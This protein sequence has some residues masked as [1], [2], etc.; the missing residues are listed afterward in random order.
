MHRASHNYPYKVASP[1]GI[2]VRAPYRDGE[3]LHW[4]DRLFSIIYPLSVLYAIVRMVQFSHLEYFL[5]VEAPRILTAVIGTRLLFF[6]W[7]W[8]TL[9]VIFT[10]SKLIIR[11]GWRSFVLDAKAPYGFSSMPHQ[12]REY[13]QSRILKQT[14]HILLEHGTQGIVLLGNVF[15]ELVTKQ[16]TSKLQGLQAWTKTLKVQ[17]KSEA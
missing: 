4:K 14:H 13:R 11:T 15:G 12:D 16:I 1:G 3:R 17:E 8:R 2:T 6:W 10:P 7:C 9:T 5:A